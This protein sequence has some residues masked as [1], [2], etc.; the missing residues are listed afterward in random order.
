MLLPIRYLSVSF[1]S[2]SHSSGVVFPAPKQ[3]GCFLRSAVSLELPFTIIILEIPF[4]SL[5]LFQVC[6]FLDL[7]LVWWNIS[8]PTF[9]SK[10]VNVIYVF[11]L[12][13]NVLLLN[14]IGSLVGF[15]IVNLQL[16]IIN[17]NYKSFYFNILKVLL[18]NLLASSVALDAMLVLV[19][20]YITFFSWRQNLI[21]I[22]SALRF[23]RDMHW[24]VFIF[25]QYF[26]CTW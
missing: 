19:S 4:A 15:R 14:F 22:S 2:W 6:L 5:S 3:I 25:I 23:H 18:H 24:Y 12:Y 11:C 8:S 20:L 26:Y 17:W 1:S 10:R 21:F 9:M 16:S 13:K 7:L